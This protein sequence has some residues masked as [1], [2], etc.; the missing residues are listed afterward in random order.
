[1]KKFLSRIIA[2][3]LTL[4][5]NLGVLTACEGDGHN[6]EY[7]TLKYDSVSHWYECSCGEKQSLDTHE[8]GTATETQKAVCEVCNQEYGNT[9]GESHTHEYSLLK[10][11]ALSHWQEC[12]CGDKI[13][14][15]DHKG[16][17]ATTTQKA[18]CEICNQEYGETINHQ[19]DFVI[20]L[21][22]HTYLKEIATCKQKAKFY[23]SCTCGQSGEDYFEYG[24]TLEHEYKD[25][26]CVTCGDVFYKKEGAY[27]YFGKY[28]QTLK[29]NSVT[30]SNKPNDNGYFIG[31]DG[32]EYAKVVADTYSSNGY[33]F[34][35]G[36]KIEEGN[37]YYFK[38]E[39]IKWKILSESGNE[40]YLLCEMVI[41]SKRY[42]ETSNNYKES[43]I[44]AW[45]N[46]EF[47]N[48]AFNSLQH[49][50]I[51]LT[52]V[53]NDVEST[54]FTQ[55][56][57]VCENTQDKVFLISRKEALSF[58]SRKKVATDYARANKTYIETMNPQY[59][60]CASWW[61]RSPSID[62]VTYVYT[63]WSDSK[64]YDY[65]NWVQEAQIGIVP[66]IKVKIS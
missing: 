18:I 25:G 16:G 15:E 9:L 36:A 5:L 17:T 41:D 65:G 42:D 59:K 60:G 13:I 48:K 66:A 8:G 28:P 51:L 44:R 29:Q 12:L 11:D 6:H 24:S 45:L 62:D 22:N 47:Y 30:I 7:S 14:I 58:T 57:N 21:A 49:E 1:M 4:I 23:Y 52:T 63:V 27:F 50:L 19:H 54:G 61:L 10:F 43:E 34:S 40:L 35:T 2:L 3:T 53:D 39:P 37:E 20:T 64:I 33:T 56:A 26:K 55:N 31:S 32:E 38:V 46:N